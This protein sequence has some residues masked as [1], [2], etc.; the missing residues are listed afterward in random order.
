MTFDLAY[1]LTGDA[2]NQAAAEHGDETPV[3]NDYYIV[4]DNPSLRTHARLP[5][6]SIRGH[7][8]VELLRA[9]ERAVHGLGGVA[10]RTPRTRCSERR[11]RTGSP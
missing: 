2:A 1:F 6:V 4:N 3:P 11:S 5:T 8:L 10:R 9:D 7:R